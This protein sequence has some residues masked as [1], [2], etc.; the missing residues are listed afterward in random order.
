ML[1]CPSSRFNCVC[2]LSTCAWTA[3]RTPS[4]WSDA[5]CDWIR[6][7][8]MKS[9]NPWI[10]LRRVNDS[11]VYRAYIHT[12]RS[13]SVFMAVEHLVQNERKFCDSRV[14]CGVG[15]RWSRRRMLI[16]LQAVL[17]RSRLGFLHVGKS[18]LGG[19]MQRGRTVTH[20][21]ITGVIHDLD[22]LLFSIEPR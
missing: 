11:T 14:V 7:D 17:R 21:K 19:F 4:C 13:S 18:G 15:M 22:F 20:G 10:R 6:G 12:Y 9:R 2:K 8:S 3:R 1:R 5:A 16:R